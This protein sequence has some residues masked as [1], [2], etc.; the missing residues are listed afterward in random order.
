MVWFSNKALVQINGF[1][2]GVSGMDISF[3][4]VTISEGIEKMSMR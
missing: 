4:T 3:S 2:H 1:C